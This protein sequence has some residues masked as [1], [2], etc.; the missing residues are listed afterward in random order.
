MTSW[1]RIGFCRNERMYLPSFE[2]FFVIVIY[3]PSSRLLTNLSPHR[4][5]VSRPSRKSADPY[6]IRFQPHPLPSQ[7]PYRIPV[8]RYEFV[9]PYR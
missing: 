3:T 6:C 4:T 5:R 2:S 1:S 7:P 9:L 8:N